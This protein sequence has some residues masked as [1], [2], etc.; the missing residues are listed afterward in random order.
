MERYEGLKRIKSDEEYESHKGAN[1]DLFK[2]Y[3]YSNKIIKRGSD[4]GK[5][6]YM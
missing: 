2:M 5:N 3:D 4:N 6:S 1:A